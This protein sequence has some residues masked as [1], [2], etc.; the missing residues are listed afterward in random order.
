MQVFE[1]SLVRHSLMLVRPSGTGK[2]RIVE[3]LQAALQQI[4][5]PPDAQSLSVFFART[6]PDM[7]DVCGLSSSWQPSTALS[8]A[9]S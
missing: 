4:V 8:S 5:V 3:V 1:M 9:R 6:G 2:S 7:P